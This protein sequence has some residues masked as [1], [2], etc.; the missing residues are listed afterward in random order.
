MNPL[1]PV[2]RM[3]RKFTRDVVTGCWTWT[4]AR[5]GSGYA[6][7]SVAGRTG[8]A[9]RASYELLVGPIPNGLEIDHLCENKACVNPAHLEPVTHAENMARLG[10]RMRARAS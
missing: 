7:F 10:R 2:E 6:L 3:F 9:H 1:S 8:L 4:A 5:D